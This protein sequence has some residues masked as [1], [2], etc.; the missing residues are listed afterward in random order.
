[1]GQMS[2]VSGF[3]AL[4]PLFVSL[5]LAFLAVRRAQVEKQRLVVLRLPFVLLLGSC[6]GLRLCLVVE[7]QVGRVVP[8]A[9]GHHHRANGA[10]VD[11]LDLEEALDY[12]DVFRLD[13]LE[14]YK[15]TP[16]LKRAR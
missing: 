10:G 2:R 11:V 7:Q 15:K 16:W 12:V 6:S 13:I 9:V 1:M 4:F 8:S 5:V 3:S 14:G